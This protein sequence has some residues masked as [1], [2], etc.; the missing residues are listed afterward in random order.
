MM[1][2]MVHLEAVEAAATAVDLGASPEQ[3]AR[4]GLTAMRVMPLAAASCS[5][6]QPFN[7]AEQDGALDSATTASC[8]TTIHAR[9]GMFFGEASNEEDSMLVEQ[10]LAEQAD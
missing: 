7:L 8:S 6:I 10:A 3:A 5:K 9:T 2:V 4:A 1:P